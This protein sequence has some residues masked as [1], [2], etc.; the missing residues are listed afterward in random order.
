M[1][2]G[3]P[4]PAPGGIPPEAAPTGPQGSPMT[5]PTPNAGA[6]QMAA[7]QVE[8]AM[9]VLMQA[10]GATGP[11]TKEGKIIIQALGVLSK[12]FNDP[13]T[14]DL[15]PAQMMEMMRAQAPSGL[16]QA[17]QQAPPGGPPAGGGAPPGPPMM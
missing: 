14:E 11:T 9:S 15:V 8:S 4:P 10:L 1:P 17:M 6:N 16:A 7:V 2:G 12:A 3:A 13:K 5:Q